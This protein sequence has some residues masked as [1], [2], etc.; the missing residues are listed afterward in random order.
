LWPNR[1]S[2]ASRFQNA[3]SKN[4][5]ID[6]LKSTTLRIFGRILEAVAAGIAFAPAPAIMMDDRRDFG[7]EG[8][9]CCPAEND[10][11]SMKSFCGIILIAGLAP[12]WNAASVSAQTN[13]RFHRV[14]TIAR[15]DPR[16]TDT[17]DIENRSASARGMRPVS[18][19]SRVALASRGSAA[20]SSVSESGLLDHYTARAETELQN[21]ESNGG[22]YSTWRQ[23][24]EPLPMSPQPAAPPRSHTYYP[25]MRSGVALSQP[26]TLTARSSMFYP[27]ICCSASRSQAM[28]GAGHL[29][30]SGSMHHR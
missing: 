5:L 11:D 7:R 19:L 23:A 1:R 29:A 2:I 27:G 24:H 28:N 26:V 25:G 12:L 4:A 20:T 21:R 3:N 9:P 18:R 16:T 13:D 6:G 10:G 8:N 30:S 22:R 15:R 14:T 17:R